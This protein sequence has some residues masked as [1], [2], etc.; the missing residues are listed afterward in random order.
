VRKLF[1]CAAI[2]C[3][4]ALF[5]QRLEW[6]QTVVEKIRESA[7][8]LGDA[9]VLNRTLYSSMRPD[10]LGLELC[11]QMVDAAQRRAARVEEKMESVRQLVQEGVL[12]R[13]ELK[14]LEEELEERRRTLELARSRAEFIR[15]LADMAQLEAALALSQEDE[16]S[17]PLQERFD[18]NGYFT[19]A[20]FRK[21]DEAFRRQFGRAL[22]V[23]AQ[24]ETA[25]HRRLGLD[26]RGRVDVALLPDSPEGAW[27][28]QWLEREQIPYYAFRGAV[29]G[30]ASAAHIHIGP[31][32]PR[33][34]M[35]D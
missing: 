28:R 6:R 33:L 8:D 16:D 3:L 32:S 12:A 13:N 19:H 2:A 34:R 30:K 14:L 9:D 20:Q 21:I 7:A 29:R 31:P 4:P 27:L 35:A 24:G 17:R 23:S 5:G 15:Q 11:D 25:F 1:V 10:E 22:P 26:H 18:G